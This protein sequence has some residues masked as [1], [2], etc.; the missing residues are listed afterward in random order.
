MVVGRS[1]HCDKFVWIL[2]RC[3]PS[4]SS[5][6]MTYCGPTF[7]PCNM[8]SRQLS[9]PN[10]TPHNWEGSTNPPQTCPKIVG[11]TNGHAN[12][13]PQFIM[14]KMVVLEITISCS[15]WEGLGGAKL[16][17][18]GGGPGGGEDFFRGL[19]PM[20]VPSCSHQVPLNVP[21]VPNP[22]L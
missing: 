12:K 2:K 19:F 11:A 9:H 5:I 10:F 14:L 3:Q 6:W 20:C 21:Q 16:F 8:Q 17:S 18:L 4:R 7:R 13:Y 15:Q 22:I 1:P